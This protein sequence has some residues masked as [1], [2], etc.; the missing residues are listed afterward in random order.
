MRNRTNFYG[1]TRIDNALSEHDG[2]MIIPLEYDKPNMYE[3]ISCA[4][5]VNP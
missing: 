4:K 5:D 1:N 3:R 2:T